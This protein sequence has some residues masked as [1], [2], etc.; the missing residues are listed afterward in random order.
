[1]MVLGPVVRIRNTHGVAFQLEAHPNPAALRHIAIAQG[2][3]N[4]A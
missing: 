3:A 4:E 2:V 1:M